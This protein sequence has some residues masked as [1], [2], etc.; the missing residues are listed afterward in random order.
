MG[1][2]W[3]REWEW[4]WDISGAQKF[5]VALNTRL[6]SNENRYSKQEQQTDVEFCWPVNMCTE[7]TKL[8]ADQVQRKMITV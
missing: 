1:S 7:K 5:P 8:P 6:T 4:Q 2:L 3:S